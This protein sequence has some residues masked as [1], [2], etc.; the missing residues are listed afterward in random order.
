MQRAFTK[1]TALVAL[2]IAACTSVRDRA[3]TAYFQGDYRTAE[4][5]FDKLVRAHPN[6]ARARQRRTQA[7]DAVLREM[8][9]ATRTARAHHETRKAIEL[10]GELLDQRAAWKMTIQPPSARALAAE[11]GAAGNDISLEIDRAI[12]RGPLV[13]EAQFARRA[14]LLAYADFGGRGRSMR[15]R[16]RAVGRA[17]C[18]ALADETSTATPAWSWLVDRYCTHFG[19]DVDIARAPIQ[20]LRSGLV[21]E[22]AIHGLRDDEAVTFSSTLANAFRATA[23]YAADGDGPLHATVTGTIGARYS[24]QPISMSA[25]WTEQVPYTDYVTEQESYQEPYTD[26]ESYSEQVPH[27]EY[28][29]K[30][31]PCL[32]PATTDKRDNPPACIPTTTTEPVTVYRTEWKT[33]TVTKYRTAY[34]EVTKPVTRYR[35]VEHDFEYTATELHGHYRSQLSI[36]IAP[37][38]RFAGAVASIS[39]DDTATALDHDVT[40]APA[41]VVPVHEQLETRDALVTAERARLAR[42]AADQLDARYAATYCRATSYTRDAAAACARLD[43]SRAPAPVHVALRGTFGDDEPLLAP[44]LAR[45]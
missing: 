14:H 38:G 9:V 43:L 7:R 11:V 4:A 20:G 45:R 2:A 40:F 1:I 42:A 41:G 28:R 35:D 5:L 3:E 44:L 23:W 32:Q 34:R 27:T 33:R 36:A 24:Q 31:E 21:V 18:G 25:P 13:A 10:L 26:T 8:L 12:V 37:D 6:D 39:R 19:A 17:R 22:G 29:T 30:T 16:V 15:N